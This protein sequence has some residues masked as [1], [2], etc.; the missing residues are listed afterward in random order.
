MIHL[1]G[2][3]CL[4]TT[5]YRLHQTVS[6]SCLQSI[7]HS[8]AADAL[9]KPRQRIEFHLTGYLHQH[10]NSIFAEG[11]PSSRFAEENILSVVTNDKEMRLHRSVYIHLHN[12]T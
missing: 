6:R 7:I 8:R 9:I 5:R 10:E 11:N 3:S 12:C 4:H 2:T 1:P